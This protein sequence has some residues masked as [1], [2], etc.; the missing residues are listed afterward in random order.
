M[1][2]A[3]KR[4]SSNARSRNGAS[5]SDK[6]PTI[7]KQPSSETDEVGLL[8]YST[9]GSNNFLP[10]KKSLASKCERE[11]GRLA[12]LITTNR[13]YVPAEVELPTTPFTPENDPFGIQL[14]TLMK[15]VEKREDAIQK[16]EEKHYPMSA[17]MWS[18][19]STASQSVVMSYKPKTL[20]VPHDVPVPDDDLSDAGSVA[21]AD[22]GSDSDDSDTSSTVSIAATVA[23]A[24]ASDVETLPIRWRSYVD[25]AHHPLILWRLIIATH[26]GSLTGSV[27]TDAVNALKRYVN[28]RQRPDQTTDSYKEHVDNAI[29]NM[30]STVLPKFSEE[31]RAAMYIDNLDPAR[32]GAMKSDLTNDETKG[33]STRPR[34]L[35]TAHSMAIKRMNVVLKAASNNDTNPT[36][37]FLAAAGDRRPAQ[38]APAPP[39]RHGG[40]PV[41]GT[42]STEPHRAAPA[43]DSKPSTPAG[44]CRRCGK[45]G[46]WAADCRAPHPKSG[47]APA[48]AQRRPPSQKVSVAIATP[49]PDDVVFHMR[50]SPILLLDE[51][52]DTDWDDELPD[53]VAP[54]PLLLP[55]PSDSPEFL[56]ASRGS[57][58]LGPRASDSSGSCPDLISA[59]G[60][61]SDDEPRPRPTIILDSGAAEHALL[62]AREAYNH[63]VFMSFGPRGHQA[64]CEHWLA[65]YG[66]NVP[67]RLIHP[68][69]W[70][71]VA[72]EAPELEAFDLEDPVYED[73]DSVE[74]LDEP[75]HH[76]DS[77]SVVFM[78]LTAPIA[79]AAS[80]LIAGL[81]ST[82]VL[83]D[84]GASASLF[85]NI[86]ML[87]NVRPA[88]V[89]MSVTGIS[90]TIRVTQVGDFGVFGEVYYSPDSCVN[91]LAV[92][93]VALTSTVAYEH[94]N[95]NQR[96]VVTNRD[97][98]FD[99]DLTQGLY[100]HDFG[101]HINSAIGSTVKEREAKYTKR[102]VEAAKSARVLMRTLGHP[103]NA[104]L[105][106]MIKMGA[107]LNLP[108][109]VHDV[110]RA[111]AIYGSDVAS[112]KGKTKRQAAR[113]AKVEFL[114]PLPQQDQALYADIMFVNSQLFLIV[115]AEPLGMVF[116]RWLRNRTAGVLGEAVAAVANTLTQRN[117]RPI[118][119]H[120][121][122]EKGIGALTSL[123]H[124]MKLAFNPAGP[125]QHVPIVENMIK[126]IKERVRAVL[127]SLFYKLPMILL[128]NLV[129]HCV[130]RLNMLPSGTRAD[131]TSPR[132]LFLQRK[133]DFAVDLRVSFGDYVQTHEVN[134]LPRN[135]MQSRAEPA[136]AL[137]STGNLQGSVRFYMIKSKTIVTR[138]RWTAM[139]LPDYIIQTMNELADPSSTGTAGFD[140]TFQR[141]GVPIEGDLEPAAEPTPVEP[142][143]VLPTDVPDAPAPKP[144]SVDTLPSS[145]PVHVNSSPSPESLFVPENPFG[146]SNPLEVTT[147]FESAVQVDEVNMDTADDL[148]DGE[149]PDEP[150]A[151][152]EPPSRSLRAGRST[153]WKTRFSAHSA[154][155]ERATK[156]VKPASHT[157]MFSNVREILDRYSGDPATS[158]LRAHLERI[159]ALPDSNTYGLHISVKRA[160]VEFGEEAHKAIR[161]EL[162]QM[163]DLHVWT[164]VDPTKLTPAE[165]RA[166][167]YSS[168]FLKEKRHPNGDFDVLKARLVANGS[169]Q[170]KSLYETSSVS[171]PTVSCTAVFIGAG[172]AAMER[173]HVATIDIV[174]A[175]LK[176]DMTG[177]KVRVRL[178]AEVSANLC[179]LDTTYNK[180]LLK[181]GTLIVALDKAMYGCLESGKLLFDHVRSTLL[182]ADFIQ[183]EYDQCVFNKG[184]GPDQCT[185]LVYVDDIMLTCHDER[186]LIAT[187]DYLTGVYKTVKVNRGTTHSYLGMTL[188]FSKDGECKITMDGY[189]DE[190]IRFADI[191][192]KASSPATTSLF[193]VRES[194][195]PLQERPRQHFHSC[196]AKLLYLAKR[197]RPDVLPVVSFLTTR[198]SAACDDD[199]AKLTRALKYLNG[200]RGMGMILAFDPKMVLVS[201]VDVS[202]GV[203]AD[204]KSHTGGLLSLGGGTFAAKSTK[205]KL[206]AK[207]STEG[208]LIGVS[209]YSGEI[210][211]T[212]NFLICQG[213]PMGEATLFQDNMSTIAMIKNGRSNSDRTRHINIRYFFIKD[214]VDA[215]E[216]TIKHKPTADMIA[217]ILTKPLQG[218]LFR[219]LRAELLNWRAHDEEATV[220]LQ[221]CVGEDG[222]PDQ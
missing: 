175:Y 137:E 42:K 180:F 178:S 116:V 21:P 151:D 32:Y 76:E 207:S 198:V 117:F 26:S 134:L 160:I 209:D 191:T 120:S 9:T 126:Q 40:R 67:V 43:G 157:D 73:E 80:N 155:E 136:I 214:R 72:P 112:L 144:M 210:I 199:L 125:E 98:R 69:L 133:L 36:A 1:L 200:T 170:D 217:D 13:A 220:P 64:Y 169:Q 118:T 187:L 51:D 149:V 181:D 52:P 75:N 139:P 4:S 84:S 216:I 11:F 202:Y 166:V 219:R 6:K 215:G 83:L 16:L 154:I 159:V 156:R 164:V 17:Y 188:D 165:F 53:L 82:S 30:A 194:S 92:S 101:L 33:L 105:I 41:S 77:D 192:G 39:G 88:P 147:S 158:A 5:A 46:H 55:V 45:A 58:E 81:T 38:R 211:E 93:R 185:A 3:S 57:P 182:A 168:M 106:Q 29:I 94:D 174:G 35:L 95:Y 89:P 190:I 173:R 65:R 49:D 145:D 132:E 47:P 221:E 78:A 31:L 109:T 71:V 150:A 148:E 196:V 44:D 123:L 184:S 79:P 86:S 8:M 15:K 195:P 85:Y 206:V 110:H 68:R 25:S 63:R 212:R 142:L 153:D 111:Q 152:D 208:E 143:R 161:K 59:S 140:P 203:H 162:Q 37:V 183:N 128:R 102:E 108:T 222:S 61:S 176:I 14:R 12:S 131:P 107:I 171:S 122:G 189:I 50:F 177:L 124:S 20:V 204:A 146:P 2:A 163:L 167:I 119:M 22:E 28:L 34:T 99:F 186:T 70:P 87:S 54:S 138:D 179:Q 97:H 18:K 90:G 27:I 62:V 127:N 129:N 23:A 197:V 60:D 213:Y 74:P 218:D 96:F 103:S 141:G 48:G 201:Y 100:V 24:H 56:H 104:D 19:L 172:L 66:P 114:P 91:I 135:S 113:Q 10:W 121:D 130:T 193:D 205:Q 115:V 7:S